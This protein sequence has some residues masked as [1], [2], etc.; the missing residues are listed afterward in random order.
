MTILRKLTEFEI[1]VVDMV[2]IYCL[3]IRSI[4]EYN[5]CVWFSSITQEEEDD[6]ERVQKCSVKIILKQDYTDYQEALDYLKLQ[7]LSTRRDKLALKFAKKCTKS[8]KFLNL[9]P[10]NTESN[11]RNS[12]THKVQ[13]A[14]RSRLQNASIPAMQR[15][16]N[17]D[18]S[19]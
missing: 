11:I 5:S 9:F 18:K 19:K 4:L 14:K 3:Y 16:L 17:N 1:P 2:Q 10:L 7:Y 13:F 15:L 6:L 8:D 12:E